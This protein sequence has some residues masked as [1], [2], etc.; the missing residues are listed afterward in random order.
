MREVLIDCAQ[1]TDALRSM[2]QK[3]IVLDPGFG[4]GKTLEQNYA[5]L[6]QLE[7]M[8]MTRLPVLVG[9]SRKSMVYRLLGCEPAGALNGST[10]LHAVAL[11]KGASILRVHDVREAVET[12]KLMAAMKSQHTSEGG[13]DNGRR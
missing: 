7:R 6:A 12:V 4:F 13:A 5:I 11:M 3:D 2:G 1:A 8:Q 10:A 9:V